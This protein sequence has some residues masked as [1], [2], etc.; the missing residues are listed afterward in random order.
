LDKTQLGRAGELAMA[1]YAMVSSDGELQLFTPVADDDHVDATAGR[2]GGVPAIAIQVKTA[3]DVDRGGLVEAK[4]DYPVGHVREHRAFLYVV[5]L[6]ASVRIEAAWVVPSLDFNRLAY[7]RVAGDREI[8]EF[9]GDP[10]RDDP[11]AAF[12]VPPLELGPRLLSV[13]DSQEA[14]I[15]PHFLRE[16]P[17]LVVA[18]RR[19]AGK[20]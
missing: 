7:R 17:G 11:F 15:P 2:R 12:R 4:A 20:L 16:T 6:M 5:L 19:T 14:S 8:L 1:L 9:R 13:I 18:A 3:S 10:L